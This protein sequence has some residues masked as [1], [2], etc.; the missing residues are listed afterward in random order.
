MVE[1]TKPKINNNEL[2]AKVLVDHPPEFNLGDKVNSNFGV[3]FVT[4]RVFN[5]RTKT[6]KYTV[7]PVSLKNFH[8]DATW[9]TKL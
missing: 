9:T 6:W 5:E 3:S 2:F 4:G 7:N 1:T 8:V